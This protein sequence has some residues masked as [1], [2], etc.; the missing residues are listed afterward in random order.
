MATD[1]Q[2][3]APDTSVKDEFSES[4]LTEAIQGSR[5][6]LDLK[7]D[8][9]GEGSPGYCESTW[10]RAAEFVRNNAV[11]LWQRFHIGI[12]TPEIL[13]GPEGS[14][15]LHWKSEHY[16]LLVNMPASSSAKAT[17]YGDDRRGTF[18]KG[19]FDPAACNQ[20]L[21]LWLADRQ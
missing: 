12:A 6:I 11:W 9:D 7:D 3:A 1:P 10:R 5:W 19:A 18:I 16:D 8:H 13:P 4:M 17:F 2:A 20:G 14:I 15:D 21:L